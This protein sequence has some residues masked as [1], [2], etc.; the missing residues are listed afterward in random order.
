MATCSGSNRSTL[1][2]EEVDFLS[3]CERIAHD[4]EE[5][6]SR[7]DLLI[8]RQCRELSFKI[9][10]TVEAILAIK[11]VI[12]GLSGLTFTPFL[13]ILYRSLEKAK[14]LVLECVEEDWTAV[15]VFQVQ[16]ES[17]F[18]QIW[19]D[20]Q[21]CYYL[22]YETSMTVNAGIPGHS[23][24]T[25]RLITDLLSLLW[26]VPTSKSAIESDREDLRRRLERLASDPS[27]VKG[28]GYFLRWQE[29][30]KQCLAR[31]LLQKFSCTAQ[32][33][34]SNSSDVCEA[35]LWRKEMEPPGTWGNSN[36]LGSGSGASG[37]CRTQWL[38]LPCARKEFHGQASEVTF[39]KEASILSHLKH[40]HIVNFLCC[41]NG[42]AKGDRFI[43]MELME[44]SL[45][46]VIEDRRGVHFALPVAV[47]IILQ[48]AEG[49]YYLHGQGVAHRDL[50][51]QNVVVNRLVSPH[52]PDQYYSVKLVDFGMSKTKVEVSKSDTMSFRG[53]GTTRYRAPEVHPDAHPDG[54]GKAQWLR[55]DV[56][57]FAMTCAHILSLKAPFE[58]MEQ[59]S[60]LYAR[61][62]GG[63]RPQLPSGL[64]K[65]LVGILQECWD[66]NPLLRPSF[67]NICERLYLLRFKVGGRI[68]MY[69]HFHI[70][71]SK[72][73]V[74]EDSWAKRNGKETDKS[75]MSSSL[76]T[77]E[78]RISLFLHWLGYF[79]D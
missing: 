16:N 23:F 78:S 20:V 61:L 30:R 79:V 37:V 68:M 76:T 46:D 4:I 53:I 9:S 48:I 33:C 60:E 75:G 18:Q 31:H 8:E 40:P 56:Y 73:F 29:A 12:R 65:E 71:L 5:V 57:S 24:K 35:G 54:L 50:K 59:L 62:V 28:F 70:V 10:Q 41:G 55:V 47:D 26:L 51:P 3:V 66:V 1:V 38:G 17:S 15:A 13:R 21:L 63:E 42:E 67:G 25:D 7:G 22:I 77:G 14:L 6:L 36:F 34:L 43:A 32:E 2:E 11:D 45:F 69:D 64:P 72:H 27:N 44:K 39:L 49:M 52:L 58:D 74:E 19:L